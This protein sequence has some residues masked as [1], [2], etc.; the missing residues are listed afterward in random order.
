MDKKRKYKVEIVI[1]Y[2][3]LVVCPGGSHA[4]FSSNVGR[5]RKPFNSLKK[6]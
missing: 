1:L 2:K 4:W 5:I 3:V 6:V